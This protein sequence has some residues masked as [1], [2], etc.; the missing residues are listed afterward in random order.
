METTAQVYIIEDDDAVR[1]SLQ[2]VLES[3]DWEV[4]AYASAD[5]FLSHYSEHI[6][7]CIILDIRMPGMNGM[8]SSM[9]VM[10]VSGLKP[11]ETPKVAPAFMA[12]GT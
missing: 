12:S 7:G 2:M 8:P 5:A 11:G 1:D 9:A 10:M 3:I 4:K 6:A